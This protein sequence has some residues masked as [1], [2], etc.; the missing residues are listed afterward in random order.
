MAWLKTQPSQMIH[1][2]RDDETL[3]SEAAVEGILVYLPN[4]RRNFKHR[5]VVGHH[6]FCIVVIRK[7]L[8]NLRS[9]GCINNIVGHHEITFRIV[10]KHDLSKIPAVAEHSVAHRDQRR[11][12]DYF[13]QLT[14]IESLRRQRVTL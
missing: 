10:A 8:D 6:T 9:V 3:D 14:A 12:Q 11:R 13:A 5:S 4:R 7:Y 1:I 2:L